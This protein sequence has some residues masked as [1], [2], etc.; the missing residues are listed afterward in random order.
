MLTKPTNYL[1]LSLV[2]LINGITWQLNPI[3]YFFSFL[4]EFECLLPFTNFGSKEYGIWLFSLVSVH[5]GVW[6]EENSLTAD[7]LP[8]TKS[9]DLLLNTPDFFYP[10]IVTMVKIFHHTTKLVHLNFMGEPCNFLKP[11]II[12]IIINFF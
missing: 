2:I 3:V 5:L 8:H 4:E 12:I 10:S 11:A 6:W 1:N 7:T 9:S